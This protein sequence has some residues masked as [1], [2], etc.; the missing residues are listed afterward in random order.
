MHSHAYGSPK[1]EFK[2]RPKYTPYR[3]SPV[4]KTGVENGELVHDEKVAKPEEPD[5]AVSVIDFA[6]FDRDFL[7]FPE[8]GSVLSRP[9]PLSPEDSY[10]PEQPA[11]ECRSPE[12]MPTP[13][14]EGG[15]PPLFTKPVLDNLH[16]HD[17]V[18]SSCRETFMALRK[19][20]VVQCRY[21]QAI[22]FASMGQIEEQ[23]AIDEQARKDAKKEENIRR[24]KR[25]ATFEIASRPPRVNRP[26]Q[27]G[28]AP[29]RRS[30]LKDMLAAA[31]RKLSFKKQ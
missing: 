18:C 27:A 30:S 3:P 23:A 14:S 5:S 12:T 31:G 10:S 13:S 6:D 20:H 4:A 1:P 22:T 7:Q 2:E 29:R 24:I 26:T 11:R 16:L 8:Y 28:E 25:A 15:R 9:R 21:C 19:E 17:V